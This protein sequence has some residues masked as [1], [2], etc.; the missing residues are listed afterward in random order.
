MET[1]EDLIR[2]CPELKLSRILGFLRVNKLDVNLTWNV[3]NEQWELWKPKV[4]SYLCTLR[5]K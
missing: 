2:M 4:I 3:Q 5:K 1:M